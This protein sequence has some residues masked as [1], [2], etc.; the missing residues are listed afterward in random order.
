M[1]TDRTELNG[2][3]QWKVVELAVAFDISELKKTPQ[4]SAAI[5]ESK[6]FHYSYLYQSNWMKSTEFSGV[7]DLQEVLSILV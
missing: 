1:I 7:C 3:Q 2:G 6:Y 5:S 4:T